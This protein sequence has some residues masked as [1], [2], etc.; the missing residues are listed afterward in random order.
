MKTLTFVL[1]VFLMSASAHAQ[2]PKPN[3][4]TNLAPYIVMISGN[5]A[6]IVTTQQAFSR[7]AHEG[8][9]LT[10]TN[11]IGVLALQKASFTFA[12]G[13]AMH[14]LETHGHPKAA[15]ALG[16][17]DGSITWGVAA[18]NHGVAR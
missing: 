10:D 12:V 6:D 16:Y 5:V 1:V 11:K 4:F 15:K 9:G 14:L 2:E 17:I 3:T 18:H 8:N 7:G 13:L